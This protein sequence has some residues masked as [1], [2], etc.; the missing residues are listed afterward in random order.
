M[1]EHD[2]AERNVRLQPSAELIEHVGEPPRD[3]TDRELW[4]RQAV[5]R[6]LRRVG[7]P[8]LSG[9]DTEPP[10]IDG[11]RA[12]RPITRTEPD[13]FDLAA[14][15]ARLGDPDSVADDLGL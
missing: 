3:A 9:D 6:E 13:P 15:E 5:R 14:H 7:C 12:L 10:P 4:A 2:R 1:P 8:R 11:G